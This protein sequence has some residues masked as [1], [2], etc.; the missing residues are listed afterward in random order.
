MLTASA[1]IFADAIPYGN[2][3]T[4]APTNTFT[5]IATGHIEGYFYGFSAADTD[6]IQ[7]CDLTQSY[8]S[9]YTFDNQT[10]PIGTSYNFGAVKAG[11]VLIFNL[12]NLNTGLILSSDPAYS[13]D[14][15]N[16][17]YATPYT[18]MVNGIPAPGTFVGMEDLRVPG[19]DLDYNDDQFVFQNAGTASPTPEPSYMLLMGSGILLLGLRRFFKRKAAVA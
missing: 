4:L 8:C 16:H 5:A 6:L 10:T 13:A 14:G 17:A 3:G 18:T 11:D 2:V 12:D 1:P 15:L 7:M 19:S 9:P